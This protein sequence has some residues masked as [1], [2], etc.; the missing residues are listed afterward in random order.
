MYVGSIINP[1]T[2]NVFQPAEFPETNFGG[3]AFPDTNDENYRIDY[4][5]NPQN[6][7]NNGNP[8]NSFPKFG[9]FVYSPKDQ[10]LMVGTGWWTAM[11]IR[12]FSKT[13]QPNDYTCNV[14]H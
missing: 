9:A 4:G 13:L 11:P 5:G 3:P 14:L 8:A 6:P 7:W 2:G 12:P 1:T 10:G